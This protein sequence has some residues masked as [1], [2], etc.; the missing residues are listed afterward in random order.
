[1]KKYKILMISIGIGFVIFWIFLKPPS[2]FNFFWVSLYGILFGTN[3][4]ITESQFI[5]FCDILIAIIITYA[6]FIYIKKKR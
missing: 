6:I 1:M 5:Y 3:N 4:I 2:P